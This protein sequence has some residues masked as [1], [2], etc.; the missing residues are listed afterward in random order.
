MKLEAAG[1]VS[2]VN[3]SFESGFY[4]STEKAD[5]IVKMKLTSPDLCVLPE[6]KCLL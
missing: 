6:D 4:S 1:K 5:L 3:N 2:S